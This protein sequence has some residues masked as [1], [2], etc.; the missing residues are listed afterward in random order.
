M[1]TQTFFR[2]TDLN[3]LKIVFTTFFICVI[4]CTDYSSYCL[5]NDPVCHPELFL[6]LYSTNTQPT[7]TLT[8]C[9]N[10]GFCYIYD[11]NNV[12]VGWS[13]SAL[14]GLSGADAK[15]AA[16]KPG[17]LPGTGSDYKALLMTND[18]TRDQTSNWILFPD[19]EYR[20]Q[21]E[22]VLGM[23]NSSSVFSFPLTNPLVVGAGFAL[24][25]G[26]TVSS[27]TSWTIVGD[28]CLNW[29]GGGTLPVQGLRNVT[30][31]TFIDNGPAGGCGSG[32]GIICIQTN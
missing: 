10:Q 3:K 8:P 31:N 16:E 21:D 5:S 7:S 23:T 6:I 15:C 13:P 29:T 18:G 32:A 19:M 2:R 28:N 11:A 25:T 14:G 30:L 17:I 24:S 27:S 22:S 1:F 20:K 26:I 4:N 12:G 9:K